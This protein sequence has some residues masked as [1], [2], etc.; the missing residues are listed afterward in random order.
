MK[1]V[2][3]T[4]EITN[5]I[6]TIAS[7]LQKQGHQVISIAENNNNFY[8]NK[9]TYDPYDLIFDYH[10][11]KYKYSKNKIL[12]IFKKTI[13]LI[14]KLSF[15]IL[16][17]I[18]VTK[19][20]KSNDLYISIWEGLLPNDSDLKIWKK[21]NKKIITLFV[22]SDVR[23]YNAYFKKYNIS[24]NLPKSFL[25]NEKL[26]LPRKLNKVKLHEKYSDA[27]FSMPDQS[28]LLTRSYY[29][30]Q[31][32]VNIDSFIFK[33]KK[34]EIPIIIHAPSNPI[35]KGTKEI[36]SMINKLK[37]EGVQFEFKLITNTPHDKIKEILTDADI[38][39]DQI[40]LHGPGKLGI[41]AMASGCVV[42]T[43]FLKE[44]PQCFKPPVCNINI[45]NMYNEVK[46]LIE[47]YE[48]RRQIATEAYNYVLKNNNVKKIVIEMLNKVT[49]DIHENYDY[50]IV[51]NEK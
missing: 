37:N 6:K 3:G 7:E 19:I 27:I 49:N 26:R 20:I 10:F 31:L 32:P 18:T 46:L 48:L 42:A 21:Y 1:I 24:L 40:L 44:S 45:E 9:Y 34:R 16:K 12:S 17:K 29:H 47:N 36:L 22:G 39:I 25:E 2:I 11:P 35:L 8:N 15:R 43:K 4:I 14:D 41:E 13:R 30:K 28:N 50:N 5:N 51:N 38:L 23:D 33:I